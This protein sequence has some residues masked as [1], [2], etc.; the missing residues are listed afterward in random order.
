MSGAGA[1]SKAGA[2]KTAFGGVNNS[3]IN[4]TGGSNFARA[5]A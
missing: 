2:G 4:T 5:F 3:A 1:V